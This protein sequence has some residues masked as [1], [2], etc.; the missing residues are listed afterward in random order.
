[1]PGTKEQVYELLRKRPDCYCSGEQLAEELGVS[2]TAVWKAVR[3]LKAEGKNIT[4]VTNRGYRLVPEYGACD[5]AF[6][7]NGLKR[8]GHPLTLKHYETLDSTNEEARRLHSPHGTDYLILADGQTAGRGRRGRSFFS[9]SGTGLY[10]S[11]LLHPEME[12]SK[13]TSVTATAAVAV[14][15]A[16]DRVCFSGEDRTKIKWV[17]DIFLDGRKLCGILTEAHTSPEDSS[18]N[19]LVIGIGINLLPPSSGFPK[20]IKNTAG[21]IFP[22]G[23]VLPDRFRERLTLAI[24]NAFYSCFRKSEGTLRIYRE[25]S[26]LMNSYVKINA[27]SKLPKN[28]RYAYVTGITDRLELSIRY[29]DGVTDELSSGEVSVV[30][31]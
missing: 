6:L 25:K 3:A 24:V 30:H 18:E 8:A 26:C 28:R 21:T 20:E 31:Y 15:L 7:E 4:A 1:M 12:F 27:F 5:A 13:L 14:S 2:R 29:P 9:P 23:T 22:A 17:N 16:I 11:L 19:Y 10:L